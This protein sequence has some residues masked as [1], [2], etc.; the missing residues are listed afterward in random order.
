VLVKAGEMAKKEDD[1]FYWIPIPS[2]VFVPF[3]S[4]VRVDMV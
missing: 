2:C 3:Y 4:S 1:G